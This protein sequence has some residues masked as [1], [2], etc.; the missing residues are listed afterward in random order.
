MGGKAR[1]SDLE[2]KAKNR[3]RPRRSMHCLLRSVNMKSGRIVLVLLG[4]FATLGTFGLT[5]LL[6]LLE[7]LRI[8]R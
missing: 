8:G 4:A 1:K 7:I 3:E 5:F 6:V 2:G